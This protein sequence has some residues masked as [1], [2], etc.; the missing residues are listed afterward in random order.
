MGMFAGEPDTSVV[1]TGKQPIFE[2]RE[3]ILDFSHVQTKVG[4]L[5][6]RLFPDKAVI[7]E[8]PQRD[9]SCLIKVVFIAIQQLR[10]RPCL[11]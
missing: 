10:F 2:W 9:A 5:I 11:D 7:P 6:K 4:M 1:E 3:R 8:S